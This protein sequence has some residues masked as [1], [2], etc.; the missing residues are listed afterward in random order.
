MLFIPYKTAGNIAEAV[1][2]LRQITGLLFIPRAHVRSHGGMILT[3][4]N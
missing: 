2:E 1:S 3:G 4:E